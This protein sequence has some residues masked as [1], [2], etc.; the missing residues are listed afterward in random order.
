VSTAGE[1]PKF[2][3]SSSARLC[4]ARKALGADGGHNEQSSFRCG[5]GRGVLALFGENASAAIVC[6]G[7]YHSTSFACAHSAMATLLPLRRYL[8]KG[9]KLAAVNV[10]S[11]GASRSACTARHLS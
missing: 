3:G 10:Q 2:G 8:S 4:L 5:D 11:G 1:Q 7:K 6:S 9:K